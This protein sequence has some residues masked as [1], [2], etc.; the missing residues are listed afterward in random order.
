[1]DAPKKERSMTF[2]IIEGADL[3]E[4]KMTMITKDFKKYLM[5]GKG[6][7]RS[8]SYNKPRIPEKQNN[9]GCYECRKT[10]HHIKNCPQW[11]IEWKKERAKR[12][13][14][15]KEQ[16]QPKKNKGSTK[17]MV[18]AWG[19]S[20]AEDSEGEDGDEQALMAIGESDEES[21]VSIIHFKDEIKLLSKKRLSELLLDFIDESDDL[22][23]KKEQLSKECVILKAKC[24]NLEL[25]ASE[26]ES[27]N[28]EL[29][30]QVR[31]LDNCPRA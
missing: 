21:E 27:K 14:M 4:D 3:E 1:M 12:R 22:N 8:G 18:A 24:K 25:R 20:S 10:D 15:K 29:K 23:N 11:E 31:E 2:T 7:S 5:R 9:K 30:N 28:A 26:S 16:V 19:E 17:A 13:N 6:P